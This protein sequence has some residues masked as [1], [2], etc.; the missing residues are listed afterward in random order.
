MYVSK[1]IKTSKS[2]SDKLD[3]SNGNL[4]LTGMPSNMPTC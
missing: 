1:A 2:V 3:T 4:K